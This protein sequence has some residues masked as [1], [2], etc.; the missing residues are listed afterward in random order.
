[1]NRLQP[2]AAAWASTAAAVAL[3]VS[4]VAAA[5]L[6]A[7]PLPARLPFVAALGSWQPDSVTLRSPVPVWASTVAL[8]G[9][10]WLGWRALRECRR[11]GRECGQIV[12]AQAALARCGGGEVVVVDLALPG[13]HAVPR[14]VTRRGRVV[15][16]TAMLDLL[17]DEERAAAIAHERA[18]LRHGH[19]VFLTLMGV[20]NAL[21]PLLTPMRDDLRYPLERWADEDAASVTHRTVIASALVKAAIAVLHVAPGG[22][23]TATMHLHGFAVT[24][25]VA[26][27]LDGRTQ[28]SRLAWALIAVAAIAAASFAWALHDT[29][30]IFRSRSP[31]APHVI[32]LCLIAVG[33]LLAS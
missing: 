29:R 7:C 11:L 20:A 16:T 17:D 1:V 5:V 4:T 24:E 10:G 32:R 22:A 28:R 25:R 26:A 13:A 27:L 6:L 33:L 2:H 14:T 31:L 8:V 30:A 9:L 15:I 3:A 18:H 23:A 12:A 19:G 21:N